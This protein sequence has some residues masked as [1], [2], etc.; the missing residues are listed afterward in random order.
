VVSKLSGNQIYQTD[1]TQTP[2]TNQNIAFDTNT[3]SPG[4]FD[5]GLSCNLSNNKKIQDYMIIYVASPIPIAVPTAPSPPPTLNVS[6]TADPSSLTLPSGGGS[7]DTNLTANVSGT[8]QGTIHYQFDCTNNGSYEVDVVNNTNPYSTS[9]CSYQ[10][11]GTYTAR[12]HVERGTANPVNKT[13][14][15]VV[16]SPPAAPGK[17]AVDIK[18]Q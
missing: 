8:A 4:S 3:L 15:I 16:N 17:P 5:F 13:T 9:T 11:T 6:L 12:V 7:V 2:I 14:T 18:V 1:I 10:T